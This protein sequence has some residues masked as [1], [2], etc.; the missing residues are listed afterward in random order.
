MGI[1]VC[2]DGWNDSFFFDRRRYSLDPVE[3]LVTA[4]AEIVVNLSAAPWA[5]GKET[6]RYHMVRAAANRYRLPMVYVNQVG[7]NV[8]LQFDGSSL[9]VK[10][11]GVA[12]QPKSFEQGMWVVDTE[13]PWTI[14]PEVA[15]V[16]EMHHRALVQGIRDYGV[17]FGF[18]KVVVGLSG[19]IDSAVTAVLAVDA[20]GADN[21][22]GLAMPSR[23][24]SEHSVA[25]A[26]Q[27]AGNL[28]IRLHQLPISSLQDSYAAVLAPVFAGTETGLAEENL[29]ARVRGTLLMAYANKHGHLLLTT[30][31]KSESAVG[32]CTL[33]GDMCGALAVIGDL[34]KTEVYALARW[35]NRDRTRIPDNSL[36]KPPS[37]DLAIVL[38]VGL[39]GL[40]LYLAR[41][42]TD[43]L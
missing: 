20:V 10:P 33:Y 34:W 23:H 25:D 1:A 37:A 9:A 21:T 12:F 39:S 22:V 11:E 29:Q 5:R 2:E 16:P 7:G 18:P 4:G 38:I 15:E 30:G 24:S 8:G 32:Y 35:I 19:G 41:T 43:K 26:E 13:D 31:N 6:F 36:A 3:C 40:C 27:L 42:W 28:G 17:K 14:E